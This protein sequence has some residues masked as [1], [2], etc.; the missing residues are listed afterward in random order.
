M[1]ATIRIYLNHPRI[2]TIV[3]ADFIY[4][5]REMIRINLREHN[6]E[7]CMNLGT[8]NHGN[9]GEGMRAKI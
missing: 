5:R 9:I 3:A 8:D 2:I 6:W 7:S 1:L 4:L